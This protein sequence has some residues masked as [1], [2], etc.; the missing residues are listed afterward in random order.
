MRMVVDFDHPRCYWHSLRRP[1]LNDRNRFTQERGNL[2]PAFQGFGVSRVLLRTL[3]YDEQFYFCRPGFRS[4]SIHTRMHSRMLGTDLIWGCWG[5]DW[6]DSSFFF[7]CPD[8]SHDQFPNTAIGASLTLPD[9]PLP[10]RCVFDPR[11]L[12]ASVRSKLCGELRFERPLHF[13]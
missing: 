11:V 3:R 8:P 9:A 5:F 2:L 4:V 12:G 13:I 1:S 7:L 6:S 10:R